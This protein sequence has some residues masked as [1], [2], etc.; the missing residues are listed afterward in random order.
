MK[1]L[2]ILISNGGTGSNLQAIID[3][4]EEKRLEA[5]IAVVVSDTPDAYG[6]QRANKHSISTLIVSKKDSLTEV[7]HSKY[8]ADYIVLAGWKMIVPEEM[9]DAF[10]NQ[11][12]NLHPGLIPDTMDAVVK[13]PDGSTGEWN[14]GKF[15]EKALQQF[16]DNN[17]TY[18]GST[19]HFL[20]HAFDF[21][22]ILKRCF[23]KINK[24]DTVE[25]LYSR[26][27]KEEH[28]TYIEVLKELCN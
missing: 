23:V 10:E 2:A 27:K 3:A 4:I 14:R 17:D 21:G 5:E 16:L 11:I 8:E 25:S 19:V 9:I 18:A 24:G 7:L 22:P 28:K 26:L 12:L 20:S 1:K 13:C 15:T 6:I